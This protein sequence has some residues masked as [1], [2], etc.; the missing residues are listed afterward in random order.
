[1]SVG[2]AEQRRLRSR[3]WFQERTSPFPWEQDGLDHVR[4]LMPDTEPYRAWAIFS[5]TAASGRVNECDLFIATTNGLHL[6]ELKGHPGQVVNRGDTWLFRAPDV[7][8]SRTL[9]NPLHLVDLKSKELRTRLTWAAGQVASGLRVPRV[10][11]AVFLSAS[12]LRSRLDEVQRARVYGRDGDCDG[13]PWIWRDLLGRPPRHPGQRMPDGL[14]EALPALL[15]RAGLSVSV[16]HLRFGD[17]W[18]LDPDPLDAGPTWE[19][20]LATRSDPVKETGRLRVYLT[21][22]QATDNDRESVERAAR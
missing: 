13:L 9:R 5:F 7:P 4:R 20:R 18:A 16:A 1:M 22:L 15:R 21:E 19:D 14:S 12:G 10:E 2:G 17:G 11:P 6:V 8:H 3:R